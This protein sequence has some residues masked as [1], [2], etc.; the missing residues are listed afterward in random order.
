[1]GIALLAGAGLLL[2]FAWF[3]IIQSYQ[4]LNRAKFDVI[5]R[6]EA[7]L[8]VRMFGAEWEAAQAR[9]YKPFTMLEKRVPLIF[10]LLHAVGIGVGVLGL[11]G[12]L[13]SH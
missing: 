12:I 6:F 8:P 9:N 11:F 1:M 2:C 5:S 13:H 3:S 4:E 7:Q 10:G